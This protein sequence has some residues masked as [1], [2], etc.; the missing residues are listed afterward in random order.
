MDF[1]NSDCREHFANGKVYLLV[2]ESI[3]PPGFSQLRSSRAF[4]RVGFPNS[5]C[6]E[7][8]AA[9]FFPI[10]STKSILPTEITVFDLQDELLPTNFTS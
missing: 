4:C 2:V 7:H 10:F 9:W 1:P 3:L 8:F 5:D 6:R